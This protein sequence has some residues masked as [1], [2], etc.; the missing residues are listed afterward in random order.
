MIKQ[1]FLLFIKYDI[2]HEVTDSIN[3]LENNKIYIFHD[4]WLKIIL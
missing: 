3:P 2:E 1:L 4:I